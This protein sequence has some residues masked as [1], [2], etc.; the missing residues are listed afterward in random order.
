MKEEEPIP[1]GPWSP[2]RDGI[3]LKWISV[4]IKNKTLEGVTVW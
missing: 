4:V 1:D 3:R 2:V